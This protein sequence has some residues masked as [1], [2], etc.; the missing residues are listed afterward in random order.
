MGISLSHDGEV[1]KINNVHAAPTE[2][3]RRT[4]F[5]DPGNHQILAYSSGMEST[6]PFWLPLWLS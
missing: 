1:K 2:G 3:E 4:D 6:P 5:V